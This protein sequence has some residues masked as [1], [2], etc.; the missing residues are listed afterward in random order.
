MLTRVRDV[1]R[2]PFRLADQTPTLTCSIGVAMYPADAHDA[3]NLSSRPTR[4]CM[5]PR[6]RGRN[7]YRFFTADMN[8]RV[9]LRL[10]LETDIGAVLWTT[11]SSSSISRRSRCKRAAC[12]VGRCCAG[13]TR[14][15]RHRPE[16][17]H[18][19]G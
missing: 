6:R 1:F 3:I 4:R 11:G 15:Q 12:S 9:Q 8:A 10:Q 17:I 5:R 2:A 18:P 7:A 14:A 19:G 16:Q 13:A